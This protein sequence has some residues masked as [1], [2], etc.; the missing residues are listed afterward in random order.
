MITHKNPGGRPRITQIPKTRSGKFYKVCTVGNELVGLFNF[1]RADGFEAH[2]IGMSPVS[3]DSAFKTGL[4]LEEPGI[5]DHRPVLARAKMSFIGESIG[6]CQVSLPGEY[7]KMLRD[8]RV[9][10]GYKKK[11]VAMVGY[12]IAPHLLP[13]LGKR[14]IGSLLLS[15]IERHARDVPHSMRHEGVGLLVANV[16]L[17]NRPSIRLLEKAGYRYCGDSASD[18][19]VV[20]Y[21]KPLNHKRR[22]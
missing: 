9:S 22:K 8:L 4:V 15:E 6:G 12:E 21:Y 20:F 5:R 1:K 7:P 3:A 17:S 18:P 10:P 19:D 14:G 16:K 13:S 11:A 2:Q